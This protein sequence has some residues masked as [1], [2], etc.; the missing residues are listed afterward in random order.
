[1]NRDRVNLSPGFASF[2]FRN[3]EVATLDIVAVS[4]NLEVFTRVP[5][6]AVELFAT[7]AAAAAH[8]LTVKPHSLLSGVTYESSPKHPHV[9]L[10][11]VVVSRKIVFSSV[12]FCPNTQTFV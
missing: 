9:S 6:F 11:Q 12:D 5:P 10:G 1:M 8:Q 4:T 3:V 7:T 2:H